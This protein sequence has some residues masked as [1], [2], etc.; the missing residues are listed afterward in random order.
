[1]RQKP[2]ANQDLDE[3][4]IVWQL[5]T[6]HV[7]PLSGRNQTLLSSRTVKKLS[8]LAKPAPK[9]S[10][11]EPPPAAS[12]STIVKP[13]LP[14]DLREGDRSGLD[15]R[16]QRRLFR[17]DFPIERRVDLHGYSAARAEIKLQSFIEDASL[18]GCRCLLVITGKCRRVKTTCA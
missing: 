7:T 16:T 6:R 10:K 5:V 1:M 14:V 2:P 3:D 9:I 8:Q 17:G 13:P 11:K 15:S 4:Q 12:S 18:T